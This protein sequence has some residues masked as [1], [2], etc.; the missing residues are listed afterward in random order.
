MKFPKNI[1]P[2]T[3]N[4]IENIRNLMIDRIKKIRMD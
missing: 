1:K 3:M 2:E 4:I